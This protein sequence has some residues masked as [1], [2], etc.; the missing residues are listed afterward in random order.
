MIGSNAAV[1]TIV[2]N[3]IPKGDAPQNGVP[4]LK[5][6][7]L[8]DDGTTLRYNGAPVS[9]GGS[10]GITGTGTTG[11]IPV[12]SGAQAIGN[13]HLDDGKTT[14]GVITATEPIAAPSL[15]STIIYSV[16]G[17]PLPVAPPTGTRATVSDATSPT[18][19]G[20]YVGGGAVVCGV[21]YNGTGWVTC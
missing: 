1:D 2:A 17:T 3:V 18:Y 15:R 13:S 16:A 12:F 21:L 7:L 4:I 6:S 20:V 11:D 14:V 5:P 9:G 19:L 10:S 8:T